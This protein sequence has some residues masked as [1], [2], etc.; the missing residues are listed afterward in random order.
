MQTWTN[1]TLKCELTL[2]MILLCNFSLSLNVYKANNVI[3]DFQ[4]S[5]F[6]R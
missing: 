4:H 2:Q 6:T 3:Y 1:L 5:S